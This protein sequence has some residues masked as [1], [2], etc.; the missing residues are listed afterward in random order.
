MT[1]QQIKC[2]VT[3]AKYCNYRKAAEELFFTVQSLHKQVKALEK[4]MG[5]RLFE[6][7]KQRL[8]LTPAGEYLYA[9]FEH[10][11]HDLEQKIRKAQKIAQEDTIR[12]T[13]V[14]SDMIE[15]RIVECVKIYNQMF[16]EVDVQI[17]EVS[18][19][20]MMQLLELDKVDVGVV[21]SVDISMLKKRENYYF[22]TLKDLEYGIICSQEHPLALKKEIKRSD[23]LN[24]KICLFNDSFAKGKGQKVLDE[25]QQEHINPG[26][27]RKYASWKN[28]ELDLRRNRGIVVTFK[29][30]LPITSEQLTFIPFQKNEI[31][32]KNQLILVWKNLELNRFI[33]IIAQNY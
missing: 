18:V 12:M 28:M 30:F 2:F 19:N 21:F 16:P 27:I 14:Q 13:I 15:N 1:I 5:V 20:Q 10:I 22:Q 26:E 25:F 29:E 33:E 32:E 17:Q 3:A 9:E 8:V 6:N 24:E 11:L 7:Q 4:E 31:K 23:I